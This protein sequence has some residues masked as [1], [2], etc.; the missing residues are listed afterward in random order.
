VGT[1]QPPP[2]QVFPPQQGW[3]GAPHAKEPL[4]PFPP[5]PAPPLPPLVFDLLLQEKPAKQAKVIRTSSATVAPAV[6]PDVRL[7]SVPRPNKESSDAVCM[8]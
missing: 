1:Q 5:P 6:P 8:I 2:L 4:P 3:P 7:L